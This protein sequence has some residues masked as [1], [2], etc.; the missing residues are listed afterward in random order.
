MSTLTPGPVSGSGSSSG[1]TYTP[2]IEDITLA[3]DSNEI[4]VTG[5][6]FSNYSTLTLELNA[7]CTNVDTAN[8]R[9]LYDS[10]TLSTGY[11]ADATYK[12][13]TNAEGYFNY[14]NDSR[15]CTALK[16]NFEGL[17]IITL[18]KSVN[19]LPIAD[20]YLSRVAGE[21]AFGMQRV[22]QSK[23]TA[24]DLNSFKIKFETGTDVFKSGTRLVVKQ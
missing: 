7:D 9:L 12:N 21:Q 16:A 17:I 11:N 24:V 19:G 1:E 13:T 10:D 23:S 4:E 8:I 22:K 15:I 5:L 6:D 18:A 20:A 3:S 14:T 2:I